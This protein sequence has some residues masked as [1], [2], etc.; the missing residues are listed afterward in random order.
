MRVL[1]RP[2]TCTFSISQP[3]LRDRARAN[4][5]CEKDLSLLVQEDLI[6]LGNNL[7]QFHSRILRTWVEGLAAEDQHH[8]RDKKRAAGDVNDA[9]APKKR[10]NSPPSTEQKAQMVYRILRRKTRHLPSC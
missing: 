3:V 5:S 1:R 4:K 2:W 10:S 9:P 7:K 8:K 6:A